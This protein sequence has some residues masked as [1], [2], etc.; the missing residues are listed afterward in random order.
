MKVVRRG[1]RLTHVAATELYKKCM[2]AS[3][4]FFLFCSARQSSVSNVAF[5]TLYTSRAL[6]ISHLP[7]PLILRPQIWECFTAVATA[8]FSVPPMPSHGPLPCPWQPA[9]E[10]PLPAWRCHFHAAG[11]A[12]KPPVASTETIGGRHCSARAGCP[13]SRSSSS[14]RP[15]SQGLT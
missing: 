10:A 8:A 6:C 5:K 12:S 15:P 2:C 3:G 9:L 11:D 13:G 7:S 14:R 4:A 1:H